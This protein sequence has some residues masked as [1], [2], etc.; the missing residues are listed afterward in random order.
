MID[1]GP[2][3][4]QA[5]MNRRLRSAASLLCLVLWQGAVY[6]S[7]QTLVDESAGPDRSEHSVQTQQHL[8][9]DWHGERAKLLN[10]GIKFDLLYVS[11]SLWN[12]HSSEKERIAS[13]N[14]VRGTVDVDFSKL[15]KS[16]GLTFHITGLWQGGG[17]MG[18]YLETIAGPS[19]MASENTFRLDSWWLEKSVFSNR[20]VARIG[21]FA[22][23]D[24]YGSQHFGSSF[25]FEP[26]GY[27]MG[28]LSATYET[29]DP[30]STP[31]F[32]VRT[33]PVRNFYV[34]SMVFAADRFPYTHN[35]S[36][37]VPQFRGAAMPVAEVGFTPGKKAA[38]V[39]SQDTVESRRGY[40]GLYQLGGAYNPG[41]FESMTLNRLV[42]GNY[43]VYGIASQA[44]YRR[45]AQASYGV[46]LT[47]GANWTPPDRSKV[48]KQ[49]T[50][51]V[52]F[53]EPLPVRLH[54]TFSMAY[55]RSGIDKHFSAATEPH[56]A[57][58]AVEGNFLIDM[59]HGV[60]FQ[61]VLQYFLNT[62]GSSR[63]A[64]VLGFR[65]RVDF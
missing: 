59:P 53:N 27:A 47:I 4:P 19:G 61:P 42:S 45:S 29:Y 9:R 41:K 39:R 43:L 18:T 55:V 62:G 50:V 25:I 64:A 56:K 5:E 2:S 63:T 54:N 12:V 34:K 60:L 24:F 26:L 13:W 11:D 52:R 17:N 37:L 40:S 22:A 32:E 14:R 20:L 51:G 7:G 10:Q 33:I 36:G 1:L 48:S 15:T 16:P 65:T 23:Q 28:N 35:T 30:P 38:D 46:D 21:Q 6:A 3:P 49:L 58:N 8:F 57:E 31:A 44:V